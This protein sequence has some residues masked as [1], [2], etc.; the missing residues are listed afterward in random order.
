MLTKK[1]KLED[2]KSVLLNSNMMILDV[3]GINDEK[4]LEIMNILKNF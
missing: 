1:I 3:N 2:I 4:I